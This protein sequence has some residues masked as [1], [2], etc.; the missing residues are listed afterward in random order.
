MSEQAP[1]QECPPAG[2]APWVMTFADLMSLLM[3]FF[4]LL[5]S[6]SEMDVQKF[7]Q[8]AGSMK[9][10]FGVQRTVKVEDIPKGTTVI[11]QEFSPGTPTPTAIP[12]IQQQTADDTH[13]NIEASQ[14]AA[15]KRAEELAAKV[16]EALQ[17]EIGDGM[18]EIETQRQEVMIRIREKGSFPSGSAMLQKSFLPILDKIAKVLDKTDGDIIVA[19][20]TDNIPI[21]TPQYPSNWVLSA[22][23]AANVVHYFSKTDQPLA[24]R[25][26]IRAH[27]D[28]RPKTNNDT[29]SNRAKNRRVEIIIREGAREQINIDDPQQ[30]LEISQ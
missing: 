6:F 2:A 13:E 28:T 26:Q 12:V 20:H 18:L 5:L 27:A 25:M 9:F 23:R 21:S 3:C 30:I 17:G 1:K 22:A 29:A 15:E 24:K 19:G 14:A 10:A 4:V 16:K 7:K 8:I 11:S